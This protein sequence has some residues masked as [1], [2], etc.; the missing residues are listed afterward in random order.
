MYNNQDY[1]RINREIDALQRRI[2]E[3]EKSQDRFIHVYGY[4]NDAIYQVHGDLCDQMGKLLEK[5]REIGKEVF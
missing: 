2:E 3:N 1:E 4:M 5:R